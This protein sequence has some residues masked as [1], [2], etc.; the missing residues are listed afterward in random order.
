M[1]GFPGFRLR[2]TKLEFV[3]R[4]GARKSLSRRSTRS[5]NYLA[6]IGLYVVRRSTYRNSFSTSLFWD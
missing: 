3:R 2:P 4:P 1:P 5:A 6:H